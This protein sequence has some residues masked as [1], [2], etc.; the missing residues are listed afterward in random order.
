MLPRFRASQLD[1]SRK[2]ERAVSEAGL[3]IPR[4]L[5]R[6]ADCGTLTTIAGIGP[7]SEQR[8]YRAL[9]PLRLQSRRLRFLGGIFLGV[10]IWII[11]PIIMYWLNDADNAFRWLK[12]EL[13]YT[14]IHVAVFPCVLG[15][16]AATFSVPVARH[17]PRVPII[18]LAAS[19][20]SI[21]LYYSYAV[22]VPR[23]LQPYE[24]RNTADSL[25]QELDLRSGILLPDHSDYL[26]TRS[27]P[28]L[29]TIWS[30]SNAISWYKGLVTAFYLLVI[31]LYLSQ[32]CILRLFKCPEPH[33]STFAVFLQAERKQA[34]SASVAIFA[35]LIL[36]IPARVYV[37][38]YIC[39][40]ILG[41]QL[42]TGPI[43]VSCTAA[44]IVLFFLL[45][46]LDVSHKVIASVVGGAAAGLTGLF[47]ALPAVFD[48]FC[49]FLAR[50]EP[51]FFAGPVVLFCALL[52]VW[53]YYVATEE[54]PPYLFPPADADD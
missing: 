7:E 41:Y 14:V 45:A 1:L 36:W 52:A 12:N 4:D 11:W 9:L 15:L 50:T 17:A 28:T 43:F 2:I 13:T 34:V 54:P 19:F 30:N 51:A 49:A 47:V 31:G 35:L 18:L 32:L 44:V 27:C 23:D 40:Y 48:T 29:A 21:L 42:R 53:S 16:L 20:L 37:D 5:L 6:A 26:K 25:K 38:W 24:T 22:F 3:S 33:G 10:A 8:I 46:L 39:N